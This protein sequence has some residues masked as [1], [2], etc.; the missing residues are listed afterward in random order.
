MKKYNWITVLLLGIVTCGI[1]G[2]IVNYNIVENNNKIAEEKGEETIKGLIIAILLGCVTCGI[3]YIFWLYKFYKQQVAIAEKSGVQVAPIN[4][5]IVLL[6]L[7]YVPVYGTY[8]LCD[9]YN[10]TIEANE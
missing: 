6:L 5:P 2:L 1:Y 10:R 8:V 9:N 7:T 4:N 3:Y